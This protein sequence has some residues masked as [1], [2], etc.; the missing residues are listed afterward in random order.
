MRYMGEAQST[1]QAV[2]LVVELDTDRGVVTF[3]CREGRCSYYLKD[4]N[5]D[6]RRFD[7]N[8]EY[9]LS[10]ISGDTIKVE[11]AERQFTILLSPMPSAEPTPTGVP[12]VPSFLPA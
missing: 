2:T 9:P 5:G 6:L 10:E 1:E 3:V 4:E 12:P 11:E 8:T 7:A